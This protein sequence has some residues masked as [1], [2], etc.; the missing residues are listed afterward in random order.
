M[1]LCRFSKYCVK[2]LKKKKKGKVYQDHESRLS[3]ST[4]LIYGFLYLHLIT[5]ITCRV[6]KDIIYSDTNNW[7][8]ASMLFSSKL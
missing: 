8:I 2:I 7:H 4:K 6:N 5:M 3:L 1:K